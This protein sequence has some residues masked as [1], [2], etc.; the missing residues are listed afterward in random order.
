MQLFGGFADLAGVKFFEIFD[1]GITALKRGGG[2]FLL[3]IW[4]WFPWISFGDD[5]EQAT[6]VNICWYTSEKLPDGMQK[7]YVRTLME[8][9]EFLLL[10]LFSFRKF[11][12]QKIAS[13]CRKRQIL[14]GSGGKPV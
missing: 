14:S 7:P 4:R 11:P 2:N 8:Q 1:S 3:L 12:K 5:L 6:S 13:V 9:L 10:L